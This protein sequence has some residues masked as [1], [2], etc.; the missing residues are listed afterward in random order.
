VC[1]CEQHGIRCENDTRTLSI[2]VSV[3]AV[4]RVAMCHLSQLIR[5][6]YNA[7]TSRSKDHQASPFQLFAWPT[8]AKLP[9]ALA[10]E[11]GST[12]HHRCSFIACKLSC[13]ASRMKMVRG[14]NRS[15]PK[16]VCAPFWCLVSAGRPT[17][18]VNPTLSN[19]C[20][21]YS[22]A[23]PYHA[24]LRAMYFIA[25][26]QTVAIFARFRSALI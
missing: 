9:F 7:V 22:F 13:F 24:L 25:Y 12:V 18:H 5:S 17:P 20:S 21:A 15:E 1:H 16:N 11:S 3:T 6:L 8:Y 14:P 10:T 23:M 19:T 2:T 4:F 26:G